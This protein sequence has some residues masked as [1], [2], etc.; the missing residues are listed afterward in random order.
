VQNID[1]FLQTNES[2]INDDLIIEQINDE[3][4]SC[5][6]EMAK[7]NDQV[8]GRREFANC[9]YPFVGVTVKC[10]WHMIQFSV[11]IWEKEKLVSAYVYLFIGQ[12]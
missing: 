2:N 6:W 11:A 12:T 5:Y 10:N 8:E 1:N 3:S 9:V 7:I 4:L